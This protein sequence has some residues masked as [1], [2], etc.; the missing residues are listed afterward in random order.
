[1]AID[2]EVQ[3]EVVSG[4]FGLVTTVVVLAGAAG[5]LVPIVVALVA[6][7]M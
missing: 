2:I 6:P 7:F 5:A 3:K 4:S 1:M